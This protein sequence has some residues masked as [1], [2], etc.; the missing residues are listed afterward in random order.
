MTAE[1]Q[2]E[3][4][5]RPSQTPGD[6]RRRRQV[7]TGLARARPRRRRRAA[8]RARRRPS[9]PQPLVSP[10]PGTTTVARLDAGVERAERLV[11]DDGDARRRRVRPERLARDP[12]D[13]ADRVGVGAVLVAVARGERR[14]ADRDRSV[15]A[16]TVPP[17]RTASKIAWPYIATGC[18]LNVTRR[19]RGSSSSGRP[20]HGAAVERAVQA[21]GAPRRS[22]AR[23]AGPP[24]RRARPRSRSRS[25]ARAAATSPRRPRRPSAGRR[26]RRRARG[27]APP[28]PAPAGS[29]SRC[30][31]VAATAD[32]RERGRDPEAA[33][34][35]R[36]Q[37]GVGEDAH[38]LVAARG[39]RAGPP[40]RDAPVSSARASAAGTTARPGCSARRYASS[41]SVAWMRNEFAATASARLARRSPAA[42]V[43]GPSEAARASAPRSQR[44]IAGGGHRLDE[45]REDA[46]GGA[47]EESRGRRR[48]RARARAATARRRRRRRGMGRVGHAARDATAR[49]VA[50]SLPPTSAG[51]GGGTPSSISGAGH[52]APGSRRAGVGL[53]RRGCSAGG[54]LRLRSRASVL[55]AARP[56]LRRDLLAVVVPVRPGRAYRARRPRRASALRVP[57]SRGRRRDGLATALLVRRRP[58]GP[59]LGLR[60]AQ[61]TARSQFARLAS[62]DAESLPRRPARPAR[63]LAHDPDGAGRRRGAAAGAGRTASGAGASACRRR[64]RARARASSSCAPSPR[65]GGRGRAPALQLA[66]ERADPDGRDASRR[67]RRTRRPSRSRRRSRRRRRAARRASPGPAPA[68]GSPPRRAR[69]RGR[70]GAGPARPTTPCTTCTTAG[71]RAPCAT[72]GAARARRSPRGSAWQLAS[73]P[74]RS[75]WSASRASKTAWRALPG[76]VPRTCATSAWRMPP[77]SR[78]RSASRERSGSSPI[79]CSSART[80]SRTAT[81]SAGPCAWS[82]TV[83]TSSPTGRR[84]RMS[85][86]AS[87]CAIRY[88]HGRTAPTASPP[89]RPASA[90][91]NAF[92]TASSASRRRRRGSRRS[93]RAAAAGCRRTSAANARSSPAP[94]R[95]ARTSSPASRCS[96]GARIETIIGP[97]AE[98]RAEA[99]GPGMRRRRTGQNRPGATHAHPCRSGRRRATGAS[100]GFRSS[101]PPGAA[102]PEGRPLPATSVPFP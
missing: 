32:G 6:V 47:G 67:R 96:S 11:A 73:R 42:T 78:S 64:R 94:E 14:H 48:R 71:A 34:G 49:S 76:D 43:A 56:R 85:E 87:L 26:P 37:D 13:A 90:L 80:S 29:P 97:K 10:L 65:D 70:G 21:V 88:S 5:R 84:R 46:V 2:R 55:L 95:A 63:R 22:R 52:S 16:G 69:A 25:R 3:A 68:S 93:T 74:A 45:R 91:M 98:S 24:T 20:G 23:P 77:T 53:R 4:A 59:V 41:E 35:D 17:R 89:R 102:V 82:G 7:L 27:A 62:L 61:L 86:I 8:G 60:G 50:G 28:R 9:G 51:G 12:G 100:S 58:V 57:A 33:L 75:S 19:M 36:R 44:G 79:A 101:S 31:I 92:W 18:S 38:D 54:G 81:V 83:A 66:V 40:R 39:P 1:R 72:R 99:T 30:A 15:P